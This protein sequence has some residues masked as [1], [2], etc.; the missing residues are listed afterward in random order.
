[1][2]KFSLLVGFCCEPGAA[3]VKVTVLRIM[4]AFG[5]PLVLTTTR[6]GGGKTGELV[7]TF[8]KVVAIGDVDDVGRAGDDVGGLICIR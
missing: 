1:M 4:G 3:A 7:A 6:C 5:S 2:Y 8:A